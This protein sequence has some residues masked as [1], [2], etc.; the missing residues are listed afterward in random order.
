M[1]RM[2]KWVS[3][4][5][6]CCATKPYGWKFIENFSAVYFSTLHLKS[7]HIGTELI[8]MLAICIQVTIVS[9]LSSNGRCFHN[10]SRARYSLRKDLLRETSGPWG[11][12]WVNGTSL[13]LAEPRLNGTPKFQLP[14]PCL[15]QLKREATAIKGISA[16]DT[17]LTFKNTS[18][19]AQWQPRTFDMEATQYI[20]GMILAKIKSLRWYWTTHWALRATSLNCGLAKMSQI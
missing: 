19:P 13:L 18:A 17:R 6:V 9:E 14:C 8:I 15:V 12:R 1:W 10:F 7:R 2:L 11:Q 3:E 5:H 16:S 20:S 4:A